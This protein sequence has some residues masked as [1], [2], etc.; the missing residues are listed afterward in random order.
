M[1]GRGAVIKPWLFAELARDVCGSTVAEPA[2]S[3]PVLYG[4]FL[5]LLNEHSRPE[6]RMG[7][8]KQFTPY[9]A[10]NYQFG[11]HLASRVQTS[12][13]LDEARERA[14]IFFESVLQTSP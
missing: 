8:L 5:D 11:H 1:L 13:S 9:F 4:T 6:H 2:V 12:T 7:R 3:L 14:E 10:Q